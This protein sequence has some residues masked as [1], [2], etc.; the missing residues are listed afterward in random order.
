VFALIA[1]AA[2]AYLQS[3]G[4][5]DAVVNFMVFTGVTGWLIAVFYAVVSCSEAS[6]MGMGGGGWGWGMGG[7]RC[8]PAPSPPLRARPPGAP[9]PN[10]HPPRCSPAQGLQRTFWGAVEV[11]INAVWTVFW[12]AAA[13]AYAAF[14]RCRTPTVDDYI[15]KPTY[16][17]GAFLASQA[18]AWLSLLLWVPSLVI[19]IFDVRRG[20]GVTGS[21]KRYPVGTPA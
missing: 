4:H 21:G 6:G 12:L 19:S 14:T 9:P 13:G 17:C 7:R 18:F 1:F 2:S 3:K 8:A 16:E 11:A 10:P 15:A 5:R 20:E